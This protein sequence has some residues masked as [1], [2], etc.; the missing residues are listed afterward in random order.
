MLILQPKELDSATARML[1]RGARAPGE[2]PA[3]AD[4]DVSLLRP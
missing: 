4:P 3:L 2:S 1:G